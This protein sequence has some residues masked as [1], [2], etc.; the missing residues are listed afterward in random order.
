MSPDIAAILLLMRTY[1]TLDYGLSKIEVQKLAYFL[2]IAGQP[3]KLD[4]AK[5]TY[6]PYSENLRHALN[7]MEG[8]YIRG[9]GN[10]VVE[11][12]IEPT[13]N[14]LSQADEYIDEHGDTDLLDRVGRVANLIDGFQ[15][16]YGMELLATV[17]WVATQEDATNP[18]MALAA[19]HA[20][21]DRKKKLM[22]PAHIEAAWTRLQ[23]EGWLQ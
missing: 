18:E 1:R 2:Q 19:V 4:F 8:H 6:G 14:A 15:S 10:G 23:E 5:H 22:S 12:E 16:P 20:W 21:N 9:I 17:H 13:P 3:L 7:R 11:A